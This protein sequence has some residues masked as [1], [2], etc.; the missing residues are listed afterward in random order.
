MQSGASS[1]EQPASSVASPVLGAASTPQQ[2]PYAMSNP[3]ALAYATQ[4][5]MAP[6]NMMNPMLQ[7]Q[8]NMNSMNGMN[9]AF[10][11]PQTMQSVLRQQSPGHMGNQNYMNMGGMPG[12]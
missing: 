6:M 8:M 9:A 1:P 4:M 7:M 10:A 2:H 12:L 3:A 11:N 5:G